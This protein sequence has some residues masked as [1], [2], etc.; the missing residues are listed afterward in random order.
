MVVKLEDTI[1]LHFGTSSP[2]T[3]AATDADST[4]TVTVEEDGVALGYSPTVT[5]VATG[6]YRVTIA[7]TT[8]N[9]FE[10]GKRYS[11]YVVATVSSVTGRDGIG[12]FECVARSQDDLTFPN[13]SGRGVD[14]DAS[15]GIE[16][17][18]GQDVQV[19]GIDAGVITA[20]EAPALANLDAAISTRGTADPGDAMTLTGAY[21]AAKTAAQAGDAMTLTVA[22][23]AAKT[24]AQAG[25]SMALTA[26]AVDAILDE[27]V[28]G[29]YTFR[30]YLRAFMAALA[31]KA[32][33]GGTAT[34]TFRDRADSK[35]RITATVDSSG[36]RTAITLDLT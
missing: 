27:V 7:A 13:T 12:E 5:N 24:A 26:A 16:I 2:T 21:D 28:E 6:L 33:G 15:G 4:P 30:Q 3:G 18:P 10:A 32:A 35:D 19:A 31:N 17:T 22:Y 25:D 20:T 9:G 36:N 8:A 14:V 23:D 34:I 11:V 1:Y 29:A